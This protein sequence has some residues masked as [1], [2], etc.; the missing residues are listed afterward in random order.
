MPLPFE[1]PSLGKYDAVIR[2]LPP[3]P[4][5][6]PEHLLT[7]SFRLYRDADL[8]MFYAPFETINRSAR[9]AIVGITPGFQQMEIAI[10]F[11]R[12]AMVSGRTN[13][14]ACIEAK[15]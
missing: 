4:I 14:E 7:D 15:A 12:A 1:M 6:S 8:E 2:S 13:T 9:V 11:A 10:R 5:Y 3:L